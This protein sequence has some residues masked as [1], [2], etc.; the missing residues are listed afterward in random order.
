M[1]LISG[2]QAVLINVGSRSSVGAGVTTLHTEAHEPT[3]VSKLGAD[4]RNRL[5]AGR[6]RANRGAPIGSVAF[7]RLS[8]GNGSLR[9][10][11]TRGLAVRPVKG[12][13]NMPP[14]A[15]LYEGYDERL[16]EVDH[17]K[18]SRETGVLGK[19]NEGEA[20]PSNLL[21]MRAES[22]NLDAP[23]RTKRVSS[24]PNPRELGV[25]IERGGRGSS[26]L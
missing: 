14:R 9:P 2:V 10:S 22:A 24:R 8:K 12:R 4:A 7:V 11:K 1:V 3:W 23:V 16:A 5:C 25:K 21:A 17:P 26:Q 6:E 18:L 19:A 20:R 15:N 13:L